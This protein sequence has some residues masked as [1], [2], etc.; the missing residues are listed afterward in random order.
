MYTS[1]IDDVMNNKFEKYKSIEGDEFYLL[2]IHNLFSMLKLFTSENPSRKFAR[3]GRYDTTNEIKEKISVIFNIKSPSAPPPHEFEI[4]IKLE[5]EIKTLADLTAYTEEL[6]RKAS[7]Y[8]ISMIAGEPVDKCINKFLKRV[9]SFMLMKG[10]SP[11]TK[12]VIEAIA[13]LVRKADFTE[14]EK[15]NFYRAI[16]NNKISKQRF[17]DMLATTCNE[18]TKSQKF[19]E[20]FISR[21]KCDC[22][23]ESTDSCEKYPR[24]SL[25]L[26][27]ATKQLQ[28]L[29][30]TTSSELILS[31]DR[32]VASG[33]SFHYWIQTID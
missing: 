31:V 1:D 32:C 24:K 30:S 28:E 3:N 4:N 29:R 10:M 27:Y 13:T 9:Q 12:D 33:A 16:A 25:A 22:P 5:K 8:R 14:S 19:D 11:Y 21:A 26:H 20:D 7:N 6:A 15:A 18:F 2:L 17:Y 23:Y